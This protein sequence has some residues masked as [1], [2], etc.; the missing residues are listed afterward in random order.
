[1]R[2]FP[3]PLQIKEQTPPWGRTT[4]F[5]AILI[6]YLI[7][8]LISTALMA[9]F[10]PTLPEQGQFFA[11]QLFPIAAWGLILLALAQAYQTDLR[12]SLGLRLNHPAGYYLR[13]SLFAILGVIVVF[14]ALSLVLSLFYKSPEELVDP[15]QALT[16]D[17]LWVVTLLGLFSAPLVEE[18][19]FRG[20][21]Q[22][23]LYKYYP[24]GLCVILTALIFGLFHSLYHG[25]PV[26]LISVYLLGLLFSYFRLRTG[27]IIPSM[28]AHLFN[29]LMAAIPIFMRLNGG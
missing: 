4:A 6:A 20:F 8:P 5:S 29:N 26:A 17:K 1:M 25:A 23:T 3:Y 7:V 12:P 18:I 9:I 27:S 16:P 14:T 24:P 15:Y 28:S 2:L 19:V 21:L 22:S 10:W 13:E 11:Q